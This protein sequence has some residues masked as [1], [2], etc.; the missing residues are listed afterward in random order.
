MLRDLDETI[1]QILIRAGEFDPAEVDISFDIPTREWSSGIQ[2]PTLNCYLFDIRESMGLREDGWQINGRGTDRASRHAPPIYYKITYL[3]T[4]WTR[5][6]EDE[7]QLLWQVLHTLAR[8][9]VLNDPSVF[10][11]ADERGRGGSQPLTDCLVGA[12]IDHPFA[13]TTIVAQPESVLKSPGEFW[14]AL[15]NQLKPSLSYA[16]TLAMNRQAVAAGKPVLSTGIGIQL[17]DSTGKLGFRIDRIF[18]LPRGTPIEGIPVEIEGTAFSARTDDQG[19]FRPAGLDPGRYVVAARVGDRVYRRVV[20]IRDASGRRAAPTLCDV[21]RDQDGRPIEGVEIEVEGTGLR[22]TTDAD[23]VFAL[24]LPP[25]RHTLRIH[26]HGWSQRRQVTVRD[27]GY[28][29]A[30]NYGGVLPD[31]DAQAG[32]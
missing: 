27:P 25:G 24:D 7:H 1:R 3:I 17:P 20:I 5:L 21:V 14:T 19:R 4:A 26:F 29:L 8:F 12:L 22:T 23:G 13:I 2:K 28:T 10:L 15:E 30:L 31:G 11:D 9:P 18:A 16:V 6:V 32:Q